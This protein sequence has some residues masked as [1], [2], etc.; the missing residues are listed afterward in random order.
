MGKPGQLLSLACNNQPRKFATV[1]C[2]PARQSFGQ[3]S[4]RQSRRL[5]PGP[6][7]KRSAGKC[8]RQTCRLCQRTTTSDEASAPFLLARNVA[9]PAAAAAYR[10]PER[11]PQ[12]CRPQSWLGCD[13]VQ[14]LADDPSVAAQPL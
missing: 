9:E 12:L 1:S 8:R 7:G 4:A 10:R 2:S 13:L 6:G 11:C 5:P 14:S 3:N